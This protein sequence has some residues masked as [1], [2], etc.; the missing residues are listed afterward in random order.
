MKSKNISY[1]IVRK[2]AICISERDCGV[3]KLILHEKLAGA[4]FVH[5]IMTIDLPVGLLI[6]LK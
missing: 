5:E 3:Y 6:K 4:T 1:L 2:P